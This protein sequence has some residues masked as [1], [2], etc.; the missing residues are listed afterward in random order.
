VNEAISIGILDNL[1]F[2]LDV[3]ELFELDRWSIR[4]LV[5]VNVL[6]RRIEIG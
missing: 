3:N 5:S 6:K 1:G 2:N 4:T